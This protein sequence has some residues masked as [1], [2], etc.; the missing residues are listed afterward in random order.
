MTERA[1]KEIPAHS[2]AFASFLLRH[3]KEDVEGE[4]QTQE[5]VW[6]GHFIFTHPEVRQRAQEFW[7]EMRL[8]IFPEF[9]EEFR[10]QLII[11]F[12]WQI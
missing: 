1:E 3:M 9:H 7:V 11:E 2:S 4:S 8:L 10:Q 5:D 12:G 6:R